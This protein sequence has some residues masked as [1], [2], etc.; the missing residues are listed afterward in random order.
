[1]PAD[2]LTRRLVPRL[3]ACLLLVS[4]LSALAHTDEYRFVKKWPSHD[5]FTGTSGGNLR[6]IAV[7]ASGNLY[8]TDYY[9]D[10]VQ[11]FTSDGDFVRT[12]G[13]EGTGTGQ[14]DIP[15]GVAVDS[16][17]NVYVV[18]SYNHRIQKFGPDGTFITAWGSYG[19][20]EG[21]FSYPEG[22][23][24]DPSDTVYVVDR[25][26]L[27]IQKFTPN[28][29]FLAEWSVATEG[30]QSDRPNSVAVSALGKVYVTNSIS[31][32]IRKFTSNGAL[33][34]R[35]GEWGTD[36]GQF[37]TTPGVAV[38]AWGNVY[39]TDGSRG[40]VQKFTTAGH[41]I[42]KWGSLGSD[43][44]ELM[45]P[46]GIAVD[47]TG[48]VYVANKDSTIHK[49]TAG[50][51]KPDMQGRLSLDTSWSHNDV[52]GPA[53]TQKLEAEVDEGATQ[54]F[55]LCVQNDSREVQTYRIYGTRFSGRW[56]IRYFN[57][58]RVGLG[59]GITNEVTGGDGWEVGPLQRGERRSFRAE[60]KAPR[61]AE[62][63]TVVRSIVR[64]VS[65]V[66]GESDALKMVVSIREIWRPNAM[67][68]LPGDKAWTGVPYHD[69]GI[70][71][72]SRK[73]EVP[74]ETKAVFHVS[75][76][77][78][79]NMEDTFKVT[80]PRSNMDWRIRYFD[81][82]TGGDNLTQ[83]MKGGG[84]TTPS[85]KPGGAQRM[86]LEVTPK[87]VALEG[88]RQ[89]VIIKATSTGESTEKDAVR[90]ITVVSSTS[91]ASCMVTGLS[92]TPTSAGAQLTFSLSSAASVSARILN[93]A[94][95]PVKTICTGREYEAGTNT[96]VWNAL[97]D[98][99][100]AV[101]NG[102]YL[103]E[104]TAMADD[105]GAARALGQVSIRR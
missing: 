42:T 33:R 80:G 94:G 61:P 20:E 6:D 78:D 32:Y 23:A 90:A 55:R 75:L 82:P 4:A 24:V 97:S 38:D 41:F 83:V 43:D 67:I 31:S 76:R 52:Y 92:A 15:E 5:P 100:T 45:S 21:E 34:A 72:Q 99:G 35:W 56:A 91:G 10:R 93:I 54:V 101:P 71:L 63:G 79:G 70:G 104:V 96:L 65:Q 48:D 87:A 69:T 53:D 44:G 57:R 27:R 29:A 60:I 12:W 64:A 37:G 89:N 28:G 68:K 25:L 8:V 40:R 16:R 103:V 73:C 13:S 3:V 11:Q 84:W 51:S 30:G 18:D 74:L 26:N 85:I 39:V 81:A 105:G 17:G 95:R 19:S 66:D 50:T 102:T 59:K 22:V 36:D 49:F 14:F 58:A 1:M 7:S 98:Q 46:R 88:D 77:N 86:R 2:A 47:A 9:K 62:P